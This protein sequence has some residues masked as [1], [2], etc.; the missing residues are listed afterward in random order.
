[1]NSVVKT[2]I[3]TAVAVP[4]LVAAPHTVKPGQDTTMTETKTV[5]KP[6]HGKKHVT[7]TKDVD[8][9]GSSSATTS[10]TTTSQK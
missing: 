9:M 8:K 10:S 2:M 5:T 4:F 1:M 7:K 3:L 6:K